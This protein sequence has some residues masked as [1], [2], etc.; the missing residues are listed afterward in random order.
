MWSGRGGPGIFR[1]IDS[2]NIFH[3]SPLPPARNGIADYAAQVNVALA[4]RVALSCVTADPHAMVPP[5]VPVCPPQ[6]TLP[7][8]ALPL[9][10]I[11]N[12]R[13]HLGIFW[14]ALRQ[15]GLVV[16]H[17][18]RLFYLHELL[19]IA[20]SRFAAVMMAANPVMAAV[21][22]E[23]VTG[24][25]RKLA[26]DYLCFDMVRDLL[27]RARKVMVHSEYARRILVRTYG[28]LAAERVTVIPHFALPPAE[29]DRAALR[30]RLGIAPR[31]VLVV[32]SGFATKAKRFD[33]IAPAL[34]TLVAE[35]RD[36]EWVHAGSERAEEYDLSAV[37]A[38]YPA[39]KG[40]ARVT[41]FVEEDRLDA[42][43]TAADINLNLRFPS[44][45]E[46]SGTLARALAAG[47]CCVVTK[48]AAYDGYPD[49]VVVKVSPFDAEAR[50]TR[51]L[52][53]LL[54][55]PAAREAFGRTAARY[56]VTTLSLDGYTRALLALC[57]E[58]QETPPAAPRALLT[59]AEDRDRVTLGPY[60]AADPGKLRADIPK[61]FL[62]QSL[63]PSTDAAGAVTVEAAGLDTTR[64]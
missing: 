36:I 35:G 50:L 27:A 7:G 16:L 59:A 51:A 17:D 37:I 10:Q 13:D 19:D 52:R 12:N 64:V 4:P 30:Q 41:G 54:D 33:W 48:T 56:A 61:G 60:A 58:A 29:A 38:A 21:R 47:T 24:A 42:L 46:S 14:R 34:A 26:T 44:V 1:A 53:A 25:R 3:Y 43:L 31:T 28:A 8:D 40:R 63:R 39:L 62:V 18:L 22:A 57:A 49:D 6:A 5:G 32:T 15:P 23:E 11:G 9:Y 2:V 55:L 20:P 45:G